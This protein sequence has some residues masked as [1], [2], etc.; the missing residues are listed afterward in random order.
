MTTKD[1]IGNL[2]TDIRLSVKMDVGGLDIGECFIEIEGETFFSF[3]FGP[4]DKNLETNVSADAESIF[5]DMS[6]IPVYLVNKAGKSIGEIAAKFKKQQNSFTGKLRKVFFGKELSSPIE[7]KP[8]KVEFRENKL[9]HI[10]DKR[11]VDFVWYTDDT[12]KGFLLLENGYLL[13]ETLCAPNGTGLVGLNIFDN[14]IELSSERGKDYLKL[15][16]CGTE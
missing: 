16:D 7:Y 9:K 13:T 6:N 12:E 2:I 3:P 15:S 5:N 14:I 8:Y 11:I 10:K 4:E 1:I